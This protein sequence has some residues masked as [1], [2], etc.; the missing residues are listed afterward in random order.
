M[1]I[2]RKDQIILATGRGILAD[3]WVPNEIDRCNFQNLLAFRFPETSQ[4]LISFRELLFSLFQ[5]GDPLK[6][7]KTPRNFPKLP[8]PVAKMIWSF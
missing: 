4:N 2:I 8:C 3:F 6:K 7:S 5:K 1:N